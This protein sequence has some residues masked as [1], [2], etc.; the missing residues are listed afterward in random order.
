MVTSGLV[1]PEHCLGFAVVLNARSPGAHA[2]EKTDVWI[3][4]GTSRAKMGKQL[5][6]LS[7]PKLHVY[8]ATL[9]RVPHSICVS[10][11]HFLPSLADEHLVTLNNKDVIVWTCLKLVH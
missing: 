6:S 3:L 4:P 10:C 2:G 9:P 1:P 5:A 7:L 8:G 11:F